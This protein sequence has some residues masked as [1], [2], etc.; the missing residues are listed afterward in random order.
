MTA[1]V[2]AQ[3]PQK[4]S[5]Q[6]V[7]RKNG[8]A[9]VKSA[10]VGIKISILHGSASGTAVYVETQTPTSN[11]NG[12]VS[13]EIGSGSVVSG[14][15]AS[16]DW[17]NGPYFLKTEIDPD[18]GTNYS[19]TGTSQLLSVPYALHSGAAEN[20]ITT[21]QA[22]AITANTAKVGITTTQADAIAA[23]T[24]KVGIT[25]AQADAITANTAKV[26]IT[27]T[28]A[29]TIEANKSKNISQ[30]LS[31]GSDAG[32]NIISNIGDPISGKD[33]VTK[34]YVDNAIQ[35]V[36]HIGLDA[37]AII[38]NV[39]CYGEATGSIDVSIPQ[40]S[41][42]VTYLWSNGSNTQD[43]ININNGEYTVRITNENNEFI[44]KGYLV[45]QNSS[46]QITSNITKSTGNDGAIDISVNG[47]VGPYQFSWNTGQITEDL[48]GLSGGN[49]ILT[50]TDGVGC[51]S[52][53]NILVENQIE[54]NETITNISCAYQSDGSI[55]LSP[56][57]GAEPY[58]YSWY[59]GNTTS[60][61]DNLSA[62]THTVTVTDAI[63]SSIQK[64]FEITQPEQINV[65]YNLS[66]NTGSGGQIDVSVSGGTAPYLFEWN[67][68]VTTEDRTGLEIGSYDLVVID[69]NGCTSNML[70]NIQYSLEI[71]ISDNLGQPLSG[72]QIVAFHP[73]TETYINGDEQE[74][75]GNYIVL[76]Q[77]QK[78]VTLLTAHPNFKGVILENIS[79]TG[80]ADVSFTDDTF[81]SLI[82]G[83]TG[84]LPV[85]SGR[86]NPIK[87]S[88]DRLYLYASNIS[89][90]DGMQQPVTF[91][92]ID[93]LKLEDIYGVV[94][95]VWF[96][97]AEGDTF[98]LNYQDF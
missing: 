74:I 87:D 67:D 28:Q 61:R 23:N 56:T 39:N 44:K 46:I 52:E 42:N 22:D 8:N 96:P 94:L 9:F 12:L 97:F 92:L 93:P 7:V 66:H 91:N 49:Y 43:L 47:G 21:T 3:A 37:M 80:S 26:G 75:Q 27:T 1:S 64:T 36:S 53:T 11:D 71:S 79:N 10:E 86:L 98:L 40:E 2:W 50:V 84:Y 83:Q 72:A 5:Y 31:N 89:I 30:I 73:L 82:I 38:T 90:N 19:I 62:G 65:N 85:L 69:Q 6:A 57:G 55:V 88:S 63:G 15:F 18:G 33:A 59:S 95:N 54:L 29:A 58:T 48:Q 13:L 24:A 16:I 68:G 76:S 14:I 81:G 17:A 20:G 77:V 70:F 78:T 45:T 25:T 41:G 4:M 60:S 35:G 34:D 32:G 51:Q